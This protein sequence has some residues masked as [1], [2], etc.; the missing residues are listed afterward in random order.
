M[1]S[2]AETRLEASLIDVPSYANQH[3]LTRYAINAPPR[4]SPDREA[5]YP[6]Q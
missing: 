3:N 5:N 6:Q 4:L 2:R 1:L